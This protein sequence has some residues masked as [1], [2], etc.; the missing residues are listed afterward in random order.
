M[1]FGPI[2]EE[3]KYQERIRD[4]DDH[5]PL[6][7]RIKT[8]SLQLASRYHSYSTCYLNGN[9][10]ISLGIHPVGV[11]ILVVAIPYYA[12]KE[13]AEEVAVNITRRL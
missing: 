6:L 7:E 8:K 1:D 13:T 10:Q 3:A 11:A 4:G 2:Q 9:G 12:V 5:L